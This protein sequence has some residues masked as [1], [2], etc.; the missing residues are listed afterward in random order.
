MPL[1]VIVIM[2]DELAEAA[3]QA[4]LKTRWIGRAYQYLER[5]GSTNDLLKRQV[6]DSAS[7]VPASGAVVLTEF[8]EH[9][10]G[11]LNRSWE[12]PPRTA[13][14]FSVLLR[15]DWPATRLSWLTMLAG[16]AVVKAVEKETHLPLA[17]K[18]PNDVLVKHHDTWHKVCGILLEGSL[19]PGQRLQHAVLG[20]GINVNIPLAEL[21]PTA[22]PAASLMVAAG[23]PVPRLPLF[24][25]LL[26]QLEHLYEAADRGHSPQPQ[27][28]QRLITLGQRVAV[29]RMGQEFPLLGTAEATDEWGQLLVRDDQGLLHT[30]MAADVSLRGIAP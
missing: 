16:L 1:L 20:I 4:V 28:D 13:L 21:P 14:L 11:R 12:A 27:W 23:H 29:T 2:K 10:R 18:W 24:A 15:P 25:E 7:E 22:Q 5:A 17:L 8:Q 30:I 6:A 26:W 3:V 19:S 9:G